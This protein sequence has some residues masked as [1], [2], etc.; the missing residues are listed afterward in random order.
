MAGRSKRRIAT[1]LNISNATRHEMTSRSVVFIADF[2][3]L[4]MIA[5]FG[6]TLTADPNPLCF[7]E[8][9][10]Y[11]DFVN[12]RETSLEKRMYVKLRAN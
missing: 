4:Y 7:L 8:S 9:R 6:V 10:A 2:S 12:T 1:A 11:F 3:I 5:A